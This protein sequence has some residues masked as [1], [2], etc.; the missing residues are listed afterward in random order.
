MRPLFPLLLFAI[1][2][3][4]SQPIQ[5]QPKDGFD[6]AEA[7]CDP[8][9]IA[10]DLSGL[11]PAFSL[12]KL[13]T[14]AESRSTPSPHEG[15]SMALLQH[16]ETCDA[17]AAAALGPTMFVVGNDENS[18]VR[19]YANDRSGPPLFE[20]N[21]D[22]FLKPDAD[23][24]EVDI[25]AATW[26]KDRLFWISSHGQNKKAETQLSRHR[27][28]A[29]TISFNQNGLVLTPVGTPYR[30]LRDAL[31]G[32]ERLKKFKLLEA[33]KIAPKKE[34]GFN[35]EGLCATPEDT[36]LIA[37]R[38]PVPEKKALLVPLKNPNEVIGGE[39]PKFE[40][41]IELD[42]GG[43]GVRSL[44]YAPSLNEYL[45][46]AGPAGGE[47]ACQ[48]YHWGGPNAPLKLKKS[49]ATFAGLTPEA[50][51]VY[52]GN[53]LRVQVLS[54][55]GTKPVDGVPCKDAVPGKRS[56]RSLFVDM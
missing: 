11:F 36:L 21:L 39:A 10:D 49:A 4:P 26:L 46:V 14:S 16:L 9:A 23:H 7:G 43:L 33:S 34:G 28:F 38:N 1:L 45:V 8:A 53:P 32:D 56:F 19:V 22:S 27:L 41:P 24:P 42:L 47:G 29:T 12:G 50:V 5:A 6:P 25:E 37:F 31:I 17:S 2:L 51:V 13:E 18:V 48:L 55:D 15:T 44:D 40:D 35:I 3:T 20:Y 54:D 30:G 52:P